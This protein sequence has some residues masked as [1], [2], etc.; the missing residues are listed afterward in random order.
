MDVYTHELKIPKERIAILIGKDG[1][2]KNELESQ[3]KIKINISA[4]IS[5]NS[6]L[7]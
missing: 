3:T 6:N 5:Y 2:V 7:S 1:Q 4:L